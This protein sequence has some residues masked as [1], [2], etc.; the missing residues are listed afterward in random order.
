M[1]AMGDKATCKS[2]GKAIEYVGP[3]WRHLGENQPRHPAI[4]KPTPEEL[5]AALVASNARIREA[6]PDLYAACA[7]WAWAE[8]MQVRAAMA[9]WDGALVDELQTALRDAKEKTRIALAKAHGEV[10]AS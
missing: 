7:A 2:C 6:A 5:Q 8:K 10:P 9:A 1:P 4:P 3:Y